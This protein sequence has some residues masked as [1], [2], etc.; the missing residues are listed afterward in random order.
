HV[1][2]DESA[3]S[4]SER[5]WARHWC[6]VVVAVSVLPIFLSPDLCLSLSCPPRQRR[7]IVSEVTPPV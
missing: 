7:R 1:G 5:W 3:A 2:G 6:G 4:A